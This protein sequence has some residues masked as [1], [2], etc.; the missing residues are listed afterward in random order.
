MLEEAKA[1]VLAEAHAYDAK[2][3]R[4]QQQAD[5]VEATLHE[6]L[7]AVDT[8]AEALRMQMGDLARRGAIERSMMAAELAEQVMSRPADGLL[9]WP[10]HDH[11]S[12]PDIVTTEQEVA[13]L[14]P[15]C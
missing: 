3:L 14:A 6:R 13:A 11:S 8:Q 4:T 12:S 2:L 9:I 1:Y 7:V 5:E 15:G 10:A